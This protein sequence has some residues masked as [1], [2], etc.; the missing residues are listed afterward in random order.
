LQ[1]GAFA[2]YS[3]WKL[4]AGV[5]YFNPFSNNDFVIVSLSMDF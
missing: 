4:T 1:R 2:Q 3:F 5:Y